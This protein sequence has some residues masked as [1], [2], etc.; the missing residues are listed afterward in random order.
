MTAFTDAGPSSGRQRSLAGG[1]EKIVGLAVEPDAA[2]FTSPPIDQLT[3]ASAM[4]ARRCQTRC[5]AVNDTRGRRSVHPQQGG[6]SR[7][8]LWNSPSKRMSGGAKCLTAFPFCS[9]SLAAL[10]ALARLFG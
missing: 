5:G 10:H 6:S 4:I 2:R 8:P 3:P 1:Q 9:A 7:P